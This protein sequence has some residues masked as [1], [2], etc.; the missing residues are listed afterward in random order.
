MIGTGDG[1]GCSV[2]WN[3][4]HIGET[5]SR[6]CNVIRPNP[7]PLGAISLHTKPIHTS[8]ERL[9]EATTFRHNKKTSLVKLKCHAVW[10]KSFGVYWGLGASGVWTG[11]SVTGINYAGGR[12]VGSAWKREAWEGGSARWITS[13]PM[14]SHGSHPAWLKEASSMFTYRNTERIGHWS[15]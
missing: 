14:E 13:P 9:K 15:T 1:V 3:W 2:C 11:L 4:G 6:H 7:T 10:K 5:R 8:Q 12:E